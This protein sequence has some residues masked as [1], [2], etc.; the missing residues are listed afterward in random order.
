MST[1]LSIWYAFT[2]SMFS[3]EHT[4]SS[5]VTT[6]GYRKIQKMIRAFWM[7]IPNGEFT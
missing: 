5:T 4:S 3:V 6:L 1:S 2:E 7:K